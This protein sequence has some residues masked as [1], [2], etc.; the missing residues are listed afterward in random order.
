MCPTK[1]FSLDMSKEI[2]LNLCVLNLVDVQSDGIVFAC[3]IFEHLTERKQGR[4]FQKQ[5][6]NN[7]SQGKDVHRIRYPA[8][9]CLAAHEEAFRGDIA[10]T[11]EGRI[12][13]KGEVRGI[14]LW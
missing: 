10:N 5:F 4:P 2:H 6:R 7:T 14:V 12:E 13:I 8:S 9:L 3:T 1:D 11:S